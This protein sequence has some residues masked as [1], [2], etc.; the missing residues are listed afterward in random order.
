MFVKTSILSMNYYINAL[1]YYYLSYCN[2]NLEFGT[3]RYILIKITFLEMPCCGD[4]IQ[5][6]TI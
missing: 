1:N 2:F 5:I 3:G 6:L 4:N